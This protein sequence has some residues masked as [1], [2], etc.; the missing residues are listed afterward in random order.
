M[1]SSKIVK[2][3]RQETWA[4]FAFQEIGSEDD[5]RGVPAHSQAG[6]APTDADPL[7]DLEETI[8]R[9]L[10]E[11][12]RRAQE[13]ERDAYQK[14]YEQGRKDGFDFGA[15]S[16][17]VIQEQM[18]T[19]LGHMEGLPSQ[20]L[21]DYREWLIRASLSLAKIIVR[22]EVRADAAI[23]AALVD[24]CM[25][26]MDR[27]HEI[28]LVLHPKDKALLEKHGVLARWAGAQ[29]AADGVLHIRTDSEMERGGCRLISAIQEIDATLETR[30]KDLEAR[31]TSDSHSEAP[32]EA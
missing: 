22:R 15:K 21:Q 2:G 3:A 29:E 28:T 7:E 9:Q 6:A 32:H 30:W 14:G 23:L 12:E 16:M 17:R 18:E 26:S 27:S 11:A 8:R 20:I 19:L 10:L 4:K 5:P 13:I 24:E 31:L 1:P 25:E